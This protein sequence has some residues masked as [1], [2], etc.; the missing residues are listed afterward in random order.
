MQ[1]ARTGT[2]RSVRVGDGRRVPARARMDVILCKSLPDGA[3]T[4]RGQ[5]RMPYG[6][7]RNRLIFA[8]KRLSALHGSGL[9]MHTGVAMP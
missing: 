3:P 1:L 9:D 7:F 2:I 5:A 8:K 6:G 4:P